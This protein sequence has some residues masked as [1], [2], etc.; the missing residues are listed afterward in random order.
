MTLTGFVTNLDGR[1]AIGL[2]QSGEAK[3]SFVR[4][5][6]VQ[7]MVRNGALTKGCRVT[8]RFSLLDPHGKISERYRM[9]ADK[10][11]REGYP[12]KACVPLFTALCY[13]TDETIISGG[14]AVDPFL[15]I[16]DN[17]FSRQD[18]V[19][20]H[21]LHS[22]PWH[23]SGGQQIASVPADAGGQLF[24]INSVNESV[25]SLS[26]DGRVV[27]LIGRPLPYTL[28]HP[29][30]LAA[31]ERSV[32]VITH[33]DAQYRL[34]HFA[35]AGRFL[36]SHQLTPPASLE[37][38]QPLVVAL[39]N[40]RALIGWRLPGLAG[41][42]WVDTV[43]E[44][45]LPGM[46]LWHEQAVHAGDEADDR[47]PSPM[48]LG[49]NDRL[50]LLRETGAGAQLQPLTQD[51]TVLQPFPPDIQGISAVT[52]DGSLAWAH[53]SEHGGL[54]LSRYTSLGAQQGWR[55]IPHADGNAKLLPVV[56]GHLWG[57]LTT[58]HSLLPID[59]SLQI[60]DEAIRGSPRTVKPWK[61]SRSVCGDRKP[62]TW[63]RPRVFW[64]RRSRESE[65][66]REV[67]E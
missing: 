52:R 34:L 60:G 2:A 23:G 45:G 42:S 14:H 38:A 54:L 35:V 31:N 55:L 21:P 59:E 65:G 57:W 33:E 43:M 1:V 66:V 26:P 51:G 47:R 16:Y 15:R 4:S 49:E 37:K 61:G 19:F 6:L 5:W 46:P 62:S 10:A 9:S 20:G 25:A 36:W 44:D 40:D 50:Y 67:S 48:L 41:V 30:S 29:V 63:R 39:P 11:G 27:Q 32:Y 58:A 18:E 3:Y 17:P 64:W 28:A 24:A 22:L 53:T 7:A 12:A 8:H 13:G 56:A